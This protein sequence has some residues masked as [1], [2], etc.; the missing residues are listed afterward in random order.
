MRNRRQS[1]TLAAASTNQ[2]STQLAF[3]T[4]NSPWMIR[5]E[6]RSNVGHD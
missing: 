5:K 4:P 2:L 1:I 3:T 6:D